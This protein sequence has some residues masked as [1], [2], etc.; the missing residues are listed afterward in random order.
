MASKRHLRRLKARLSTESL[1]QLNEPQE[2]VQDEPEDDEC[3]CCQPDPADSDDEYDYIEI[4]AKAGIEIK[5]VR[6][7]YFWS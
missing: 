1:N 3:L 5:P 6:M 2:P 7:S 4:Y